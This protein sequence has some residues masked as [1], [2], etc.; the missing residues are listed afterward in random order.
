MLYMQVLLLFAVPMDALAMLSILRICKNDESTGFVWSNPW[1]ALFTV[2]YIPTSEN[3]F[4]L[5]YLLKIFFSC[6]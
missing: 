3:K 5:M 2:G 4:E 6:L 1:N